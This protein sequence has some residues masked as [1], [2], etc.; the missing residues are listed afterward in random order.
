M[1]YDESDYY[2]DLQGEY[3]A[4]LIEEGIQELSVE[5]VRSYLAQNGDAVMERVDEALM[6]AFNLNAAH[7]FG[8][9]VVR[10]S[11][12]AELIV[13][14]LLVQP[15][16]Q[17]A[18]LSDEWSA[19]LT[20]R[21][22]RGGRAGDRELLPTIVAQWGIDLN[23]IRIPGGPALWETL[24]STVWK[25]RDDF[26]HRCDPVYGPAADLAMGAS[27][28]LLDLLVTPLSHRLGLSWPDSQWAEVQQGVGGA[29]FTTSYR[30]LDPFER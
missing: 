15:L 25:T 8:L 9:S 16:V 3:E 27:R 12:A 11:S 30:R 6:D 26:L 1:G 18:F 20:R 4:K 19:L 14:Y 21:I 22:T 5:A 2:D 28:A 29:T 10:S 7:K 17:G 23:A 13:H 24:V